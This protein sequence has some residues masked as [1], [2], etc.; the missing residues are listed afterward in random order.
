MDQR[1][2]DTLFSYVKKG[3]FPSN[4]TKNQK[5]SLRRKSKCF[6]I[7]DGVLFFR[8]KKKNADLKV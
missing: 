6:F 5:D 3:E 4:F 1:E 8:D 7:K 2:Y